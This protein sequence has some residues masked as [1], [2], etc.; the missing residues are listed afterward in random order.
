MAK[1]NFRL[2]RK[3]LDWVYDKARNFLRVGIVQFDAQAKR[4]EQDFIFVVDPGVRETLNEI[5]AY[6]STGKPPTSQRST[7]HSSYI[8]TTII[9]YK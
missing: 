5:L 4:D 6:R 7:R 9:L 1:P 3:V 2:T 8:I